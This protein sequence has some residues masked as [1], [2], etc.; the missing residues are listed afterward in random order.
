MSVSAAISGEALARGLSTEFRDTWK[1]KLEGLEERLGRVM[2][3]GI[4][5]DKIE[6]LYGY[7]EPPLHPRR[8]PWGEPPQSK[9]FRARNFA[10]VND[11][12]TS[13]VEWY[14]WQ[15]R[16]DQLRDLDRQAR[17]GGKKFAQLPLR[18]FIQIISGTTDPDLLEA[19]PNAPDG[20]PLFSAL[21]GDGA[22]RFGVVGGNIVGG[23]AVATPE[24]IRTDFF[25]GLTRMKSFKDPE[26]QP[27]FDP[28]IVDMNVDIWYSL[29]NEKVFR[30]AFIQSR[31]ESAGAAAVTNVVLESGLSLTLRS[32]S[33]LTG[34][35]WFIFQSN[36]EP[37]AVFEQ[38]ALALE[39]NFENKSNSDRSRRTGLEGLFWE[40]WRGF[41]VNLPL[42]AVQIDN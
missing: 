36:F 21:D 12:W 8:T 29:E 28:D 7:W 26:N 3:L 39:E 18:V 9:P 32:S 40:T 22:D 30:E 6:E 5:S 13:N 2:A 41:G 14:D 10:V 15:R 24:A 20:V 25:A 23:S 27:A 19:I 42:G 1:I 38:V 11:R 17:T 33:R 34:D 4:T 37:R 35:D 31:T 16:F